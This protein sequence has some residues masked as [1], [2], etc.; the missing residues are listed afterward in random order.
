M[1]KGFKNL[2]EY[3]IKNMV[4]GDPFKTALLKEL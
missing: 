3:K 1:R 2:K 4:G